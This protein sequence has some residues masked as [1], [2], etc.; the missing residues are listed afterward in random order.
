MSLSLLLFP[1]E[2]RLSHNSLPS[3]PLSVS[4]RVFLQEVRH[5]PSDRITMI[6]SRV[7]K[8]PEL[9]DGVSV[10]TLV[11]ISPALGLS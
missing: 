11:V 6:V 8:W 5:F 7:T 3:L 1:L 2:L 4:V 10:R 9:R